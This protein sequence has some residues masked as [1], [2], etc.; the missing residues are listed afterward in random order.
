MQSSRE[1]GSYT[2]AMYWPRFET[3]A[4][5]LLNQS[6]AKSYENGS[7]SLESHLNDVEAPADSSLA[8]FYRAMSG[9]ERR[10]FWACFVGWALD[11]MDFM[12]YPLVIGSIIALWQVDRGSAGLAVTVTLIASAIGGWVAG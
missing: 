2:T 5:N 12:V 10:T 3:G 9:A 1:T 4:T 11:G 7:P 6:P 8:G